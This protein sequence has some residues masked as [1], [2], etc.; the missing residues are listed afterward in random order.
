MLKEIWGMF[1]SPPY[2]VLGSVL[3]CSWIYSHSNV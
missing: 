1:Y 2:G 3:V